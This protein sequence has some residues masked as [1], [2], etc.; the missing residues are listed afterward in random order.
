MRNT[1][2]FSNKNAQ[3]Y[4][5]SQSGLV[6]SRHGWLLRAPFAHLSRAFRANLCCN[7]ALKAPT[8]YSVPP[9]GIPGLK[10]LSSTSPLMLL[11]RINKTFRVLIH[12][13]KEPET[14]TVAASKKRN[15]HSNKP[16]ERHSGLHNAKTH[17][18]FAIPTDAL[19]QAFREDYFLF[20]C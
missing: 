9:N 8:W 14:L 12:V 18:P 7:C 11:R 1:G 6:P 10:A 4:L 13:V 15:L 16:S 19:S 17:T 5:D 20:M 2:P 3:T